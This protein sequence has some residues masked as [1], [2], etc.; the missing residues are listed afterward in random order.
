MA[1]DGGRTGALSLAEWIDVAEKVNG[2]RNRAT[3][4][5][6][7]P[8]VAAASTYLA[9]LLAHDM[10]QH[11]T[12]RRP[13]K[14]GHASGLPTNRRWSRLMLDTLYGDDPEPTGLQF[15]P[16]ASSLS[17]GPR[18]GL[19]DLGPL[20]PPRWSPGMAPRNVDVDF[21]RMPDNASHSM[22]DGGYRR[23]A[24][25]DNRNDSHFLIAQVSVAFKRFHNAVLR[26]IRSREIPLP[27]WT[28]GLSAEDGE[29]LARYLMARHVTIETWH[30][31]IEADVIG[32]FCDLD[33]NEGLKFDVAIENAGLTEHSFAFGPLRAL[34]CLPLANYQIAAVGGDVKLEDIL[35]LGSHSL[36]AVTFDRW[37]MHWPHFIDGPANQLALNRTRF[38]L[39]SPMQL[40]IKIGA[41]AAIP[42]NA[43]DYAH[44][45]ETG[46]VADEAFDNAFD[47]LLPAPV[48]K[49]RRGA[50]LAAATGLQ[51][52][53]ASRVAARMP[54]ALLMQLEIA[55]QDG[56]GGGIKLRESSK[57]GE[58]GSRLLANPILSA[59]DEARAVNR[60]QAFDG[61]EAF[62]ANSFREVIARAY[63]DH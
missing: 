16:P 10:A 40:K 26:D 5:D 47:A 28:H 41:G 46:A 48:R 39:G 49:S 61:A 25:A 55:A 6:G 54:L 36:T 20:W 12:A 27:D 18:I 57:L 45:D 19:F 31:V 51:T 21:R 15:M 63:P 22:R 4:D 8:G 34:H 1:A 24:V 9:Q 60:I 14:V 33:S 62:V 37:D 29:A 3:A 13:G 42:I 38:M 56:A 7:D 50:T 44:A 59:L 32:A 11:H 58:V 53:I 23:A 30:R 2:R 43:I 52:E 35:S 17:D